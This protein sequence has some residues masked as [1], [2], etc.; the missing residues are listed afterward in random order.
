MRVRRPASP[1]VSLCLW[2]CAAGLR[3]LVDHSR[4]EGANDPEALQAEQEAA[5]VAHRAAEALRRSR[6]EV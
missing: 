3:S 6:A 1:A 4:V 2:R 5:R